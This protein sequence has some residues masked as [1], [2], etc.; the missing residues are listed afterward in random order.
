MS[1]NRETVSLKRKF[2]ND[3]LASAIQIETKEHHFNDATLVSDE[4]HPFKVHKLLIS[5]YSPVMKNILLNNPHSQPMIYLHGVKAI[6]LQS[7][8]ELIYYGETTICM[9][10]TEKLLK[11][12]EDLKLAKYFASL[13]LS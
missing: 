13:F 4:L 10:R 5:S 12:I 1:K 11:V 6:E 2:F 3:I 8:L 7:V 9:S